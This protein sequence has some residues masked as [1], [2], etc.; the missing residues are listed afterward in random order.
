MIPSEIRISKAVNLHAPPDSIFHYIKNESTWDKWHPVFADSVSRKQWVLAD[1]KTLA[2][3]DSTYVLQSQ[4][5][6]RKPVTSG[7][8]LYRFAQTDSVTLQ[9]YM[10]FQ[11][12]WYPWE[13]FSSLFFEKSYGVMMEQGLTN[14]KQQLQ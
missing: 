2:S 3:T 14:L 11:L 13:K 4:Q 12:S 9:W 6:G 8:E 7:W 10:D 1:K 5:S